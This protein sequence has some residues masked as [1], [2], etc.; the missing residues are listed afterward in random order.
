MNDLWICT[1]GD[2]KLAIRCDH[3]M[4]TAYEARQFGAKKLG[5]DP[6][7]L[8][9]KLLQEEDASPE[10]APEQVPDWRSLDPRGSRRSLLESVAVIEVRWTGSDYSHG[11]STGGRRMQ[12]REAGKEWTNV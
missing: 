7:R 10:P 1:A 4:L 3:A 11:G 2:Q 6:P 8:D 12:E 5:V 9:V